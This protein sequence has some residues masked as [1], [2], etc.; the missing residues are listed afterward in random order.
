[1]AQGGKWRVWLF[2]VLAGC[3]GSIFARLPQPAAAQRAAQRAAQGAAQRA[4][5]DWR[6]G[7]VEAIESPSDAATLGAAWTRVRFQ[8]AEMQPNGPADWQPPVTAAQLALEKAAGREVVGMLIGIPDWARDVDRLPAGLWL[9]GDDPDNLW[10]NFVRA[11]VTAYAST[12]DHWIIWNEPDI[13]DPTTP[14]HTWDGDE[15][16]FLQLQRVAYQAAKAANPQAI[17]HL[18]AMTYFWD[19]QFG[20]EQYLQRLL[21]LLAAD[22]EAASHNHYFDVATAH[23]YFQPASVYDVLTTFTTIL[24]HHGL[25]KPIWLVETNAP[26]SD[27]PDWPVSSVTLSV[28]QVEQA[29]F[30]PQA[31]ALALAAGAQRVAIYK[32]Q[33]TAGDYA[34][35]PEPFGLVRQDRSRRPAFETARVAFQMLAGVTAAERERWDEV[36]QVRLTQAD[37]VTTVAFARLPLPQMAEVAQVG[38][39]TTAWLVD[40]WGERKQ[41]TASDGVFQVALPPAVCTQPIGDYCMIGGLVYYVVQSLDVEPLTDFPPP[42]ATPTPLPTFT[43]TPTPMA[44]PTVTPS[45]TATPTLTPEPTTAPTRPPDPS[46]TSAVP[47]TVTP[48]GETAPDGAV[49]WSFWLLGAAIVTGIILWRLRRR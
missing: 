29:A 3:M 25:E 38:P 6:F 47:R 27:D 20:R 31:L 33:D 39:G 18:A 19:A 34:A 9:D 8:W 1:M 36:G 13:W 11:T 16:D 7:V 44:T 26:P 45:P 21:D 10:A 41:I 15:A 35:N 46:P 2:L 43:Q 5:V 14:G 42:L 12:I 22:P 23:I 4:A 37:R 48:A 24:R 49:P 32:L 17:V 28:L 40:M 30:M